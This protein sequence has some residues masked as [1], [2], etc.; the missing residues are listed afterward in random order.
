MPRT[1]LALTVVALLVYACLR[2]SQR[3]FPTH[4]E[5]NGDPARHAL[6]HAFIEASSSNPSSDSI[7]S[8]M[9][10]AARLLLRGTSKGVV[11]VTAPSS[12][13][14][15]TFSA[16]RASS[17]APKGGIEATIAGAQLIGGTGEPAARAP[18]ASVSHGTGARPSATAAA[19]ISPWRSPTRYTDGSVAS[20]ATSAAAAAAQAKAT[21]ERVPHLK[22]RQEL[23]DMQCMRQLLAHSPPLQRLHAHASQLRFY[24]YSPP[25]TLG[26]KPNMLHMQVEAVDNK[27][28][29]F[30]RANW[31][32]N[33]VRS[34]QRRRICTLVG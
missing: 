23:Q 3:A 7:A 18:A 12:T 11:G 19:H 10:E 34:N 2:H 21:G 15:G 25:R 1:T 9:D 6:H 27:F 22:K 5:T 13:T 24:V 31:T 29:R 4:H 17:L 14:G 26:W 16:P 8:A 28:V 33:G 32:T 30:P 20:A